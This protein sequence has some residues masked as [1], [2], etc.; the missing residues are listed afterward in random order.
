MSS[1][2]SARPRA[3]DSSFRKLRLFARVG[4][5]VSQKAPFLRLRSAG[6]LLRHANARTGRLVQPLRSFHKTGV[7]FFRKNAERTPDAS[8]LSSSATSLARRIKGEIIRSVGERSS[9]RNLHFR[10]T[11]ATSLRTERPLRPQRDSSASEQNPLVVVLRGHKPRVVRSVWS[12]CSRLICGSRPY[13][14]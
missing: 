3:R 2:H 9:F 4:G 5:F 12:H 8:P 7:N 10:S 11:S 14:D 13:T 1:D 6:V